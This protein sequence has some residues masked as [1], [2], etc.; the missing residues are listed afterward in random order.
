M[1]NKTLHDLISSGEKLC[2]GEPTRPA[3]VSGLLIA[4]LHISWTVMFFRQLCL[5]CMLLSYLSF[6]ILQTG[7]KYN[8][9]VSN[10][11]LKDVYL[12]FILVLFYS[13]Y[14]A[15]LFAYLH[16]YINRQ[17][18]FFQL[19]AKRDIHATVSCTM[20]AASTLAEV[21]TKYFTDMFGFIIIQVTV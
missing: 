13:I 9:Y 19:S 8:R 12:I 4:M 11:G 7:C 5:W 21:L 20:F 14:M 16:F 10:C 3:C 17:V 6:I 15:L 1:K 18:F 2:S